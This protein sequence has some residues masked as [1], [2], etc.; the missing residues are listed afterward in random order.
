MF[1][2]EEL[3]ALMPAV[4][5]GLGVMKMAAFNNNNGVHLQFVLNKLAIDEIDPE[6]T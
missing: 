4:N 1:T 5:E 6:L 2:K 3:D